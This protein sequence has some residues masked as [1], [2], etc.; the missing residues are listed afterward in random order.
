MRV[1]S[2]PQRGSAQMVSIRLGRTTRWRKRE[3]QQRR[4]LPA[5]AIPAPNPDPNPA[6]F[7]AALAASL[8][9]A[10][11]TALA[12]ALAAAQGLIRG[13]AAAPGVA[14]T[15]R[16]T[17]ATTPVR[18]LAPAPPGLAAPAAA[19]H[20]EQA[21]SRS[22]NCGSGRTTRK[23]SARIKRSCALRRR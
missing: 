22:R 6:R 23:R 2:R 18:Y 21:P 15:P 5:N 13:A 19:A 20:Q 7:T 3:V 10:L 8:T 17:A 9:A 14:P 11:A 1:W 12:T 4:N 16:P